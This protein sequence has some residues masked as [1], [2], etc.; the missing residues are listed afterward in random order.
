VRKTLGRAH[1]DALYGASGD[2]GGAS[3]VSLR[4]S[5]RHRH[6]HHALSL[7]PRAAAAGRGCAGARAGS[8][9][10]GALEAC[11]RGAGM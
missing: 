8:G 1:G 7:T 11:G 2:A 6:R 4:T 9:R 3:R 10:Q 5:E